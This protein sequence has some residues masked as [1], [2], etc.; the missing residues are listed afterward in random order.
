MTNLNELY[1]C[2]ICGNIVAVTHVGNNSLSCCG[3]PMT[4]L[5]ES[6]GSEG[7]EKHIPV[8]EFEDNQ[9]TVRVGSV[10]HPMVEEHHIEW[11][12]LIVGNHFQKVFL[13]AGE[14]PV[15]KFAVSE[16]EKH[17][18]ARAYCNVHGLWLGENSK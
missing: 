7:A 16:G 18:Y 1:K 8:I 14:E 11:I 9:V 15:A 17:F 13:S 5:A 4:I 12:E 10:P 2:E 3:D 6:N